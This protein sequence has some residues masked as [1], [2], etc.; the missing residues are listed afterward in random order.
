MVLTYLIPVSVMGV[1]YSR[2]SYILWRSQTI[3]ELNQRQAESI[4]SKRKVHNRRKNQFSLKGL[5]I[6]YI[7]FQSKQGGAYVHGDCCSLRR[8]L[9]SLSRLFRI[10]VHR[11][12]SHLLQI[13]PA[14]FPRILLAGHEQRYDQPARLLLHERQ[15]SYT[16]AYQ[17]SIFI[18]ISFK[19][20]ADENQQRSSNNNLMILFL[21]FSPS[22]YDPV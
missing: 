21:H 19:A 13:R 2:M 14:H 15:V 3:G 11:R 22:L 4:Q 7:G 18:I 5:S 20:E 9:A 8:L 1:C 6:H 10:P 12:P 17:R 16:I